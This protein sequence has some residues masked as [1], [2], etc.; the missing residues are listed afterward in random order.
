M[1][2][3]CQMRLHTVSLLVSCKRQLSLNSIV[4]LC[5]MHLDGYWECTDRLSSFLN[6][7]VDF[8]ANVFLKEK[9]IRSF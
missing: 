3:A 6:L 5:F 4:A 1:L 9:G 2:L 7:D 8:F